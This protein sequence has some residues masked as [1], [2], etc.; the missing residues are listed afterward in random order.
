MAKNPEKLWKTPPE[1]ALRWVR[2][3]DLTALDHSST[4]GWAGKRADGERLLAAR[5]P[6]LADLQEQLFAH[7]R[8]GGDRSVLLVLQ[9]LDTA[10]KGGIVRH[11]VGMVDPQGVQHRGFG[12]PTAEEQQHGYLWRIRNALPRPGYLGVFDRSHHEQ[13][14][15]VRVNRL[16]PVKT[17][18]K[19]FRELNDFEAEVAA[20]GTLIVKVALF[21]SADEQKERLAER[22]E[23][24]DK[25]WKYDPGDIDVRS[26]LPEYLV[27]YQEM[28]DRTST[29]VAPW[30]VVPANRKWYARLAVT[31]LLTDALRSL[32][33]GW[34]AATFDVEAE[35]ARLAAS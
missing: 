35:K 23:R 15:V 20:S 18:R 3:T 19:H 30:Y 31:E 11:V 13:V 2:G 6:E 34:P 25:H 1:E 4:P 27:A 9:G 26:K 10:G 8:T 12:V 29:A 14:L 5:A 24:P 32:D 33:L 21:V 17:W 22:L 7:G 16:E 28:L